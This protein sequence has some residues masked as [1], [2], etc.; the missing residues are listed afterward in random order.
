MPSGPVEKCAYKYRPPMP[1]DTTDAKI[2]SCIVTSTTPYITRYIQ[3][4]RTRLLATVKEHRHIF[5]LIIISRW[6]PLVSR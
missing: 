6:P 2:I 5:A 4:I 3:Q 1:E